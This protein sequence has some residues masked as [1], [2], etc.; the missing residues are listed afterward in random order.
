MRVAKGILNFGK[1]TGLGVA[2]GRE[3]RGMG[4]RLMQTG[5]RRGGMRST[6]AYH[7]V[8]VSCVSGGGESPPSPDDRGRVAGSGTPRPLVGAHCARAVTLRGCEKG[9]YS[10]LLH[11]GGEG[12][13]L[14]KSV[15][16]GDPDPRP[17]SIEQSLINSHTLFPS[18]PPSLPPSS[19]LSARCQIWLVLSSLTVP[20]NLPLSSRSLLSLSRLMREKHC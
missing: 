6:R 12:V 3:V 14:G 10:R 5:K 1:G 13:T 18:L 17:P 15:C 2:G 16:A 4:H 7:C 20:D 11:T 8:L 19:S 9:L